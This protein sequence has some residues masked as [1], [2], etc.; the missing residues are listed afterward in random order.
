LV[1]GTNDFLFVLDNG[2]LTLHMKKHC[3]SVEEARASAD[4]FLFVW[5]VDAR[6]RLGIAVR[7]TYEDA[8]LIDR[9]PPPP[10]TLEV[11]I[12]GLAAVSVCGT[13]TVRM[14]QRAYPEP[15]SKMKATPDLET[16]WIRYGGYRANRELL[17]GMAYFS[18]T[19]LEANAGSRRRRQAAA[20]KYNIDI[21]VLNKLG[22]LTSER[23]DGATARKMSANPVPYT[24]LEICWIEEANQDNHQESGR[25]RSWY[26]MRENN[27][28]GLTC[29]VS[30]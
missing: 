19:A 15:P 26:H 1:G 28:E 4:G 27:H 8:Q 16:L 18:L 9:I 24:R 13:A 11:N 30:L 6:L 5:E 22:E 20:K 29:P 14:I 23:G 10:G 7:F 21:G 17:S 2:T 12:M 25:N 3:A